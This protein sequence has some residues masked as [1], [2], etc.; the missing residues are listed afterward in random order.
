MKLALRLAVVAVVWASGVSAQPRDPEVSF[1]TRLEKTAIWVGDRFHYQIFVEH[2]PAMQFILDNVNTDTINLDPLRV[3]GV[4]TS[5]MAVKDGRQRLVVDLT[6][7]SFET[8]VTELQ[9][10]LTQTM[11]TINARGFANEQ[12]ELAFAQKLNIE[13]IRAALGE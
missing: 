10:P 9:I 13:N 2:S 3:V 6:L 5:T 1:T 8:G 12:E 11:I 4:T 7:A